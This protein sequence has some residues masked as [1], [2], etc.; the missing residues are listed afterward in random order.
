MRSRALGRSLLRFLAIPMLFRLTCEL[1][2]SIVARLLV[3]AGQY[4][5]PCWQS[6]MAQQRPGV[7]T[8][9]GGMRDDD[10][11]RKADRTCRRLRLG[12][13]L[14]VRGGPRPEPAGRNHVHTAR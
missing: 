3:V 12:D 4:P 1:P 14:W 8:V 11:H 13:R 2:V 9:R 7:T 10:L 6:K 5:R